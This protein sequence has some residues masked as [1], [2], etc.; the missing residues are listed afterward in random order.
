[1]DQSVPKRQT[2][3]GQ[4]GSTA[5]RTGSGRLNAAEAARLPDRLLDAAEALF[6]EHGYAKTTMDGIARLAGASTKTVYDRYRNKN[7]ILA[8]ILRRAND[9]ALAPLAIEI[10]EDIDDIEPRAFLLN[11]GDRI[12]TRVGSDNARMMYRL[13]VSE[14]PRYPELGDLYKEGSGRFLGLL[15]KKFDHWNRTGALPL[16][17]RPEAAAQAFL[18]LIG[19]TPRNRAML[20]IPLSPKGLK[21]HVV[22]AVEIFFNGC[23]KQD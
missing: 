3:T 20:G 21:Q 14:C 16:S 9:N 7:E 13:V 18:D 8:A 15:T 1:M 11:A 5:A 12:A 22:N 4:K 23:L 10:S 6:S 19:A 2:R 17:I